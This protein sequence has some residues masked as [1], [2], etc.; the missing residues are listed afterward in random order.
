MATKFTATIWPPLI[1]PPGVFVGKVG[2]VITAMR[3]AP[4]LRIVNTGISLGKIAAAVIRSFPPNKNV[5]T[6]APA[7]SVNWTPAAP[8]PIRT[9]Y[10]P[11][12]TSQRATNTILKHV[13][14]TNGTLN[15]VTP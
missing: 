15:P 12:L 5:T 9:T 11:P 8:Q 6:A 4:P 3:P 1:I 14:S 7:A 13:D 2:G 10:I